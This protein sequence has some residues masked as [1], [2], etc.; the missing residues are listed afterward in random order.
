MPSKRG[1]LL[2][3]FDPGPSDPAYFLEPDIQ[4]QE[5]RP[6]CLP[7][8]DEVRE[9]EKGIPPLMEEDRSSYEGKVREVI[10]EIREDSPLQKVVLSR[11]ECLDRDLKNSPGKLFDRM[12]GLYPD[13]YVHIFH[14]PGQGTWMGATPELLFD[15]QGEEGHTQALAGTR[16][17][18]E[19]Q[20]WTEKERREQAS[21]EE[22]IASVLKGS[23]IPIL[24]RRGPETVSAGKLEHLSTLFVFSAKAVQEQAGSFLQCLHPT[25]AVCG[26]PRDRALGSIRSKE[27][28]PRSFYSGIIGPWDPIQGSA[29]Y[30]NL[31]CFRIRENAYELFVGGGINADSDPGSEWE[32]TVWKAGTMKR[33]FV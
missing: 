5:D 26:V 12:N 22:H 10:S 30:V 24:E 4:L 29:L 23:D 16:P 27:C 1:Y 20:E 6:E 31:R 19:G 13:A 33:I 21:V 11:S 25:P 7:Q 9:G 17:K 2:I 28:R 8:G 3:P 14:I 15:L 32:E 18:G